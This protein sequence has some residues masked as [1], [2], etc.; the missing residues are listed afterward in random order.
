MRAQFFLGKNDPAPSETKSEPA[1]ARKR[2]NWFGTLLVVLLIL[3][4]LGGLGYVGKLYLDTQNK[5]KSIQDTAASKVNNLTDQ[6]LQA[7]VEQVGRHIALPSEK[8]QIVT[9]TNVDQLK[10]G[11]PFF[12]VAQNGDK[13]LVYTNKVILYRTSID[14]V[15]DVAQIRSASNIPLASASA[16]VTPKQSP[17]ELPVTTPQE[18][19]TLTP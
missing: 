1:P 6:E 13:L 8:P 3:A 11:Q 2:K 15:I 12:T 19:T 10:I 14:K 17:T 18:K 9:I 4:L 5:L 7:L 16:T